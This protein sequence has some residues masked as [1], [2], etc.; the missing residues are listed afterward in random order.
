ME[1]V[2][3]RTVRALLRDI[4]NLP[5][6]MLRELALQTAEGLAAIHRGGIVHRDVKPDNILVTEDGRVRLMDLGVAR[7]IEESMALTA[8]GTFMGS[9]PY[10]APEQ[11]RGRSVVPA[12]DL[13]SLGVVLYEL[14]AGWNPFRMESVAAVIH[15]HLEMSPP[16]LHAVTGRISPFFSE[17]VGALIEKDVARRPASADALA[18]LLREGQESRWWKSRETHRHEVGHRPSVHVRRDTSLRGRAGALR[19]L[20]E[21]WE[22]AR[23]G[24]GAVVLVEG[25]AGIGKTR[26]VD[27]FLDEVPT[28]EGFLLY[29]SYPPSGGLGGL[30]DA[31][32]DAF[33]EVRLEDRLAPYLR[34]S[35]TLASPFAALL[36]HEPTREVD[37]RG[38][39]LAGL[40]VQLL[41][42]LGEDRPT[43]WVVEDLHFCPADSRGVLLTLARSVADRPVML[44]LTTRPGL[45][46]ETL[47]HLGRL[48]HLVRLPLPRLPAEEVASILRDALPDARLVDSLAG[49]IAE[50]SDGIPYF[51]FELVRAL[52]E[53]GAIARRE[54]GTWQTTRDTG[55]LTVPSAIRDLLGARLRELGRGE[56][57]ILEAGAVQGF[58]FDPEL[59]A[60]VLGMGKVAVLGELAEM[61]RRSGVVRSSGCLYRFDHHQL[62]EILCEDQAEPLRRE[63]HALLAEARIAVERETGRAPPDRPGETALFIAS[64]HLRG[65][66]PRMAMPFL[67]PALEHLERSHRNLAAIDLARLALDADGGLAGKERAEI[68]LR[69]H[70]LLDL[71]GRREEERPVLVEAIALLE[72]SDDV[73]LRIK[74][75]RKLGQHHH[76]VAD[77]DAALAVFRRTR[78]L[79][80]ETDRPLLEAAIVGAMGTVLADQGRIEE[81]REHYEEHRRVAAEAGD[82]HEEARALGNLAVYHYET[83]QHAE[84]LRRFHECREMFQEL[85]ERRSEAIAT[86]GIGLIHHERGESEE[87]REHFE[88]HLVLCREI[89]YR[90]GEAMA[91]GNLGI[92]DLAEGRLRRA[93]DRFR[94]DHAIQ[95]EIGDPA[96]ESLALIYLA[97][98]HRN[99]GDLESSRRAAEKALAMSSEISFHYGVRGGRSSL[100]KVYQEYGRFDEARALL[101]ER[102]DAVP[103]DDARTRA[104][105][106][107]DLG[108]CLFRSGARETARERLEEAVSLA[109]V[110]DSSRILLGQVYLARLGVRTGDLRSLVASHAEDLDLVDRMQLYFQLWRLDGEHADLEAARGG[111]E[112]LL[113]NA[114]EESRATM[115]LNVALFREIRE[116]TGGR[117]EG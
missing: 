54:D 90:R 60:R 10:A 101:E 84:A 88:R 113:A 46:A 41:H 77:Y 112:H 15:A 61:E 107:V 24:H 57:A 102:L 8:E 72:E 17:V 36:K 68:L 5:E 83:G 27:A 53:T 105:D 75:L 95:V 64:H 96:Q 49:R 34:S 16:S 2:E 12:S 55:E 94:R 32:L 58:T 35:P 26:L 104:G 40:F 70:S 108:I 78:D 67:T 43:L 11:F 103:P 115:L 99:L 33:G 20:R 71:L 13:Y 93:R 74:A 56:R 116:A 97:S 100:A 6:A 28:A 69:L 79:A 76:F 81:S 106:L 87:A 63:Y 1:Y 86:N 51:V 91:L 47:A 23:E 42:G 65:S 9:F 80:R 38:D 21:T 22:R 14:A 44:V 85:G 89:G 59:V 50:K 18:A 98:L 66:R 39:A 45:S 4:G 109:R 30:S 31:V 7:F 117:G 73:D 114:P 19:T 52:R 62:H 37:L 111:L 29:G 82:R 110:A 25:E 48:D 92:L 3:G